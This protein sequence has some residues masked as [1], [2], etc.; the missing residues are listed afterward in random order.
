MYNVRE[1]SMT[2]GKRNKPKQILYCYN[3]LLYL[4]KLLSL[5]KDFKKDINI[6]FYEL[7]EINFLLLQLRNLDKNRKLEIIKF[8]QEIK[9]EKN[10]SKYFNEYINELLK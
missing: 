5:F 8:Y 1:I 4:K 7:K 6:L 10:I 9:K 3:Y 2:H